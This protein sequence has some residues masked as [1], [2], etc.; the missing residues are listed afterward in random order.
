MKL[1][2]FKRKIKNSLPNTPKNPLN[3]LINLLVLDKGTVLSKIK[4]K[5]KK[6]LHLTP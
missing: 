5:I 3:S 4:N 6:K 2:F 1:T